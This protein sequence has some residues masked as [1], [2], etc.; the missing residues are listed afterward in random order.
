VPQ[1]LH[2]AVAHTGAAV[3]KHAVSNVIWL[4]GGGA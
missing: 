2:R 3:S 1:D 4:L